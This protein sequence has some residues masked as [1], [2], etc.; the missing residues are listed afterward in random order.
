MD[1][2][3]LG[4]AEIKNSTCIQNVLSCGFDTVVLTG[5]ESTFSEELK[6]E[7]KTLID[8][9][10][11]HM[12]IEINDI[13]DVVG[14]LLDV[15][16]DGIS[17]SSSPS[18]LSPGWRDQAT[19][20]LRDDAGFGVSVIDSWFTYR[21]VDIERITFKGDTWQSMGRIDNGVSNTMSNHIV[22][23]NIMI[24]KYGRKQWCPLDISTRGS[25]D[26]LRSYRGT[27]R[28]R[29]FHEHTHFLYDLRSTF[30]HKPVKYLEIGSYVGESACLMMLHDLPTHVTC[31][32]PLNLPHSHY[33]VEESQ[34]NVL[35][36]NLKRDR[37]LSCGDFKIIKE[38]SQ[39]VEFGENELFDII[40]I[41]GDHSYSAVKKD[42]DHFV[43]HLAPGGYIVFDDYHDHVH[44][45]EVKSA[46]D[47]I[48]KITDL[49]ICGPVKNKFHAKPLMPNHEMN[50]FVL[51]KQKELAVGNITTAPKSI[52][53][54]INVAT[55]YR[56]NGSTPSKLSNIWNMLLK[57]SHTDWKLYITG[58][59]YEGSEEDILFLKDDR[60]SWVNMER[61]GERGMN[62][63]ED[64][65]AYLG[66]CA[67][68][69][70]VDRCEEDWTVHLDDDDE[71]TF[72]HLEHIYECIQSNPNATIISTQ[73]QYLDSIPFPQTSTNLKAMS[74]TH[75]ALAFNKSK[76][77]TRYEYDNRTYTHNG[78]DS[79]FLRRVVFDINYNYV[80]VP[81]VTVYHIS[82]NR[83]C[84]HVK[85]E[86]VCKV[87]KPKMG[88]V[89][90]SQHAY[91]IVCE[92]NYD[93]NGALFM[94][95]VGGDGR[96]YE[97]YDS[98]ESVPLI[99]KPY[100]DHPCYKLK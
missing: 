53:F 95:V 45:P 43:K 89:S 82:E 51:H 36:D 8:G 91:A 66:M 68:N 40:F 7:I 96:A 56:K 21:R 37:A 77:S 46:V 92:E 83:D 86:R 35:I 49:T 74:S 1:R 75:S 48:A 28:G 72:D 62:T 54:G 52:T 39:N 30:G 10:I 85:Y 33:G 81:F 13:F 58:D 3:F 12:Y 80:F 61:P 73:S 59:F 76:I 90:S 5:T 70:S 16:Y 99:F 17:F 23:Q 6:S 9:G 22:E 18:I 31:V 26:R 79:H 88:W 64:Q 93:T 15:K 65:W 78:A 20:T 44:S 25:L 19:C 94:M 69:K 11:V 67:V 2:L 87:G 41:D 29:K 42:Y 98:M 50:N 47:D 84:S 100:G 27:L 55:Y 57:Q 63:R 4:V 71:W 34:Y 32:D 97:K 60:V 24:K 38:Y 14:Y